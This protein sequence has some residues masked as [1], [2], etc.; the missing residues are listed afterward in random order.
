MPK[1][2]FAKR[3][4]Y[5]VWLPDVAPSEALVK[6]LSSIYAAREAARRSQCSN[7]LKQIGLALHMYHDTFNA[8][9]PAYLTDANGKPMHSWRVLILPFMEGQAIYDQYRFDEP[10]D[11]PHNSQLAAKM[12]AVFACPSEP[13]NGTETHYM[14][15]IGPGTPFET[16]RK[17]T[18]G[19]IS[20]SPGGVS[21]TL[22]VVESTTGTHWMKPVDL[23][24]ANMSMTI[25]DKSKPSIGAAHPNGANAAFCDASVR[26]LNRNTTPRTVQDMATG[27]SPALRSE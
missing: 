10:W 27:S 3:D 8:L 24:L 2:D 14:V 12:P 22:M 23:D 16:G 6:L 9:P 15:I 20:S 25:G 21:E 1:S 19:Q 5:D 18:F 11:G 17:N 7:N 13:P 4:F 26:F